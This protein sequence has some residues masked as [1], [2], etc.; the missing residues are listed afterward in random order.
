[1][2]EEDE[3]KKPPEIYIYNNEKEEV[4]EIEL[5]NLEKKDKIEI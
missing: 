1:M 2:E 4:S 5:E 3:L